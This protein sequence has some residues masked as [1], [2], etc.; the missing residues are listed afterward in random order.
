LKRDDLF[1]WLDAYLEVARFRDYS[2]IGL[3]VE[4]AEDVH[5]VAL[6]V[7][8][9]RGIIDEAAAWG[10]DVLL[11]HHGFFWP[12][13][14]LVL[15]GFRKLRI[16]ALFDADMS[17]GSYHLPL[18]AHPV[19][20]NNAQLADILGVPKD[21]REPWGQSK[22]AA[23]GVMGEF[24]AAR[25]VTELI[26]TLSAALGRDALTFLDGPDLVRRLAIVS[27]GGAGF[28]EEAVAAGAE[29]LL[30]GEP[31]EPTM[32]EAAEMGAHFVAAGHYHTETVGIRALGEEIA[33][34]HGLACRFFDWTNPV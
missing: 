23:I 8:A 30:T 1:E 21:R 4:G 16:Q 11:V 9:H 20:G 2:P 10:A 34:T 15:K 18:D 25:P 12:G 33:S 5:K 28:F 24:E 22:G 32:A 3:Q 7:S 29:L 19:V 27:G 17:L 6:G 14:P 31:R 26:E 13:E